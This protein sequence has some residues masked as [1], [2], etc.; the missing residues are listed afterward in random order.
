MSLYHR[1]LTRTMGVASNKL[2]RATSD[3]LIFLGSP[4]ADFQGL[5]SQPWDTPK[6]VPSHRLVQIWEIYL[7]T[8][9]GAVVRKDTGA[10]P[11]VPGYRWL[12]APVLIWTMALTPV[13]TA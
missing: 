6:L 3:R 7:A 1:F 4:W 9:P 11:L 12:Y 2:L 13:P 5:V 10:V 8:V